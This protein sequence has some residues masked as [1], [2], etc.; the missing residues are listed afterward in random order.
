MDRLESEGLSYE[1]YRESIK[2]DIEKET[3]INFEVKSKNQT[4]IVDFGEEMAINEMWYFRGKATS[5]S[6]FNVSYSY[7]LDGTYETMNHIGII[8]GGLYEDTEKEIGKDD[9]VVPGIRSID[10]SVQDGLSSGIPG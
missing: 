6:N 5:G 7:N 2:K 1:K 9:S 10:S 4:F 8:H 3:L